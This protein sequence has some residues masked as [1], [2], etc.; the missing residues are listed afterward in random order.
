M[1][2]LVTPIIRTITTIVP[3]YRNLPNQA[4]LS[5]VKVKIKIKVTTIVKC[6]RIAR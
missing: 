5:I 2:Q 6:L 1:Q 4:M 3:F